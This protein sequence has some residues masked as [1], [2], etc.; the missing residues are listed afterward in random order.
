[1]K[2]NTQRKER[3]LKQGIAPGVKEEERAGERGKKRKVS[4]YRRLVQPM[5]KE[6]K[7]GDQDSQKKNVFWG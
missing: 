4:T 6:D 5:Q 7:L 2:H 1:V 3:D